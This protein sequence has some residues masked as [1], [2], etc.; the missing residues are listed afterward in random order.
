MPK[1]PSLGDL[2]SCWWSWITQSNSAVSKELQ[3]ICQQMYAADA[4]TKAIAPALN[5]LL[6]EVAA[7][8]PLQLEFAG[9]SETGPRRFHNEDSCFPQ[10]V[11]PPDSTVPDDDIIPGLAIVCDGV[12]G[13][14]RGEVASQ[15]AVRALC[16]QVQGCYRSWRNKRNW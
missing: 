11:F 14:D 8:Q 6:L 7:Q 5:Q 13:H 3:D 12:G 10:T 4:T 16:L 1:I 2:A 15:M 9:G